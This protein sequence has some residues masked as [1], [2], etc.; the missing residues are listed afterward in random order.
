M[1]IGEVENDPKV[2]TSRAGRGCSQI[3]LILWRETSRRPGFPKLQL[4]QQVERGGTN[5][6]RG[7]TCLET[8]VWACP[9]ALS[10]TPAT[11]RISPVL[12]AKT[13]DSRSQQI[14]GSPIAETPRAAVL[15]PALA[16]APEPTIS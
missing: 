2:E 8:P 3:K 6:G 16:T 13:Q 7:A 4:A 15:G 10:G 11:V 14:Q 12:C 5:W 1:G 9:A